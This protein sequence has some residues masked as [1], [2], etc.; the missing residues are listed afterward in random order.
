[1]Q[2]PHAPAPPPPGLDGETAGHR[3]LLVENSRSYAQM[4][5]A[6]LRERL[7]LEVVAVSSLAAA[8]EALQH[9]PPFFLALTGLVL[10]DA[11]PA[12]IARLLVDHGLPIVVVTGVYDDATRQQ[13]AALPIIDYVLK[14]APD[15]IDYLVW[16]V[17]RLHSNRGIA[18]LVV[19]PAGPARAETSA[20]LALYGFRVC[21]RDTGAAGLQALSADPAMR[22]VVVDHDLA[23]MDGVEFT[24]RA[25]QGR[26]RDILSIVGASSGGGAP[27]IARFLKH[28]ANDFIAKPYSRE[29]FMC[30]ISQN[31]DNLEL[32]GTLQDLATRDYLTGL[33]NRRHFFDA[34][35][36]ALATQRGPVSLAML[37]IDHFKHINDTHGHEAGDAALVAVAA[38][39]AAHARPGDVVARFGGEE[40]CVLA[41]G[42]DGDAAVG[43]FERLRESIAALRIPF[44]QQSL[45]LTVSIGV[46]HRHDTDLYALLADADR[47]LYLAKA[48]GRNRIGTDVRVLA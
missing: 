6:E 13:M 21:E 24:R 44:R 30:R 23:D 16:L 4:L 5:A 43:F 38:A 19:E 20:L 39:I 37:D 15:T 46:C 17:R 48:A 31:V 33:A 45:S 12:R 10:P 22:L 40:F 28:G 29:E 1:M 34:G 8:R 26:P 41:G 2:P 42:L 47:L 11:D 25:R 32:I 36:R 18:A 27:R 35:R 9:G 14:E 3:V 7:Q